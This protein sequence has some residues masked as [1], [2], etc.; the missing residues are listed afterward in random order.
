MFWYRPLGWEGKPSY[1]CNVIVD[2]ISGGTGQVAWGKHSHDWSNKG[3]KDLL[4][5]RPTLEA[6]DEQLGELVLDAT[7]VEML[8]QVHEAMGKI[9]KGKQQL[10]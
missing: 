5:H 4:S 10:Q 7:M 3:Y 8:D 1:A 9:S 6:E 2:G